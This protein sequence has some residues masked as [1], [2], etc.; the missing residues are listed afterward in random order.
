MKKK[1][2]NNLL[3]K[4][5]SVI[6]AVLLWGVVINID[7]PT[8]TYT[9]SGIPIK[10]INEKQA[11]TDNNLTYELSGEKTVSVEVTVKI[12]RAHV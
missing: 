6:A 11:I 1:L 5:V 2:T 9:I 10:V 12:G 4:I 7:N 3:L 8:D